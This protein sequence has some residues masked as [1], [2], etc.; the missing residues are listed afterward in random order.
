MKTKSIKGLLTVMLLI[1]VLLLAACSSGATT[2]APATEPPPSTTTTTEPT[3]TGQPTLIPHTLEGRDNCLM[4]HETGVG[5][6]EAIPADH[7]GRA[8]ADCT[9]CHKTAQ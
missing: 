9:T 1:M 5:E 3:T 4:C 7:A 8:N 2:T 6:A